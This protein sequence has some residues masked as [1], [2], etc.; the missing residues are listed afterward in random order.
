MIIGLYRAPCTED[1]SLLPFAYTCPKP[2][3]ILRKDDR[4]FIY[5]N[6]LEL[7]TAYQHCLGLP[8][9]SLSD[10]VFTLTDASLG[11]PGMTTL[12]RQSQFF[13][14]SAIFSGASSY[15][16]HQDGAAYANIVGGEGSAVSSI[17]AAGA[18]AGN[19]GKLK[20]FIL[21]KPDYDSD[22]VMPVQ[23]P[24]T[25]P[26]NLLSSSTRTDEPVAVLSSRS[27]NLLVSPKTITN[28]GVSMKLK[29]V[30]MQQTAA[31]AFR[32]SGKGSGGKSP[33]I[34][35]SPQVKMRKK[36]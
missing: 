24:A 25:P 15:N 6:P 4:V 12:G 3:T 1:K 7:N 22:S 16:L 2:E 23:M 35:S 20:S 17:P 10:G 36:L 34:G 21:K 19:I 9:V 28:K 33:L 5:C 31:S 29:A 27:P 8:I 30:T 26:V 18:A 13:G 11:R 14:I 32:A